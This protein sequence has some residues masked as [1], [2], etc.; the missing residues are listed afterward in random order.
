[1]ARILD[2]IDACDG[3]VRGFAFCGEDLSS[4]ALGRVE[5]EDCA[6]EEC[7]FAQLQ[8]ARM[9]FERCTLADCDLTGAQLPTS[10]WRDCTLRG[11]RLVGC[12][13]TKGYLV[14]TRWEGCLAS[15]SCLNESKL[16]G[17]SFVECDLH[18][19]SLSSMRARRLRFEGCDL[20]RAEL[21]RTRLAGVDLSSSTLAGMRVSDT[22]AELRGAKVGIDQAPELLGLLGVK[23][24][25]HGRREMPSWHLPPARSDSRHYP[26]DYLADRLSS[27]RPT[28]ADSCGKDGSK[29]RRRSANPCS[30]AG[31]P[32]CAGPPRWFRRTACAPPRSGPRPPSRPWPR[33]CQPLAQACRTA[34]RAR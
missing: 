22:F 27:G 20:T 11:C 4:L 30:P 28:A 5:F 7:T 8:A 32:I 1:M 3:D 10:F 13:L 34:R 12:N 9:S 21:F 26:T 15:F 23:V 25:C 24:V 29:S 6:F 31:R 16:E 18:E 33:P 19:S 14:R 17:V 2:V